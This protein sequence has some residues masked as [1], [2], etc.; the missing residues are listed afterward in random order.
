M[1]LKIIKDNEVVVDVKE[2][3]K[4]LCFENTFKSMQRKIL[5]GKLPRFTTW[6][7]YDGDYIVSMELSGFVTEIKRFDSDDVEYNRLCAEELV[8]LLNKEQ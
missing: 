5:D 8:E 6:E 2:Y 1:K 7:G 4:L 3:T